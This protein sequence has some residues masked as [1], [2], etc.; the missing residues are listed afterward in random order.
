MLS[1]GDL[2]RADVVVRAE[3]APDLGPIVGDRVQLQQVILN[4]IRNA[5]DAMALVNDRPRQLTILTQPEDGDCVRVSVR[6][7][8]VGL[9]VHNAEHLF[10]A[11]YTTKHGGMGM[12]LSVSRSIVQNHRGCLWVTP[13]EGPGVTFSFS[14]PRR[15]P[16]TM[17]HRTGDAESPAL[18]AAAFAAGQP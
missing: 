8:G 3:L 12:G 18:A 2:Q 1:S 16:A 6:D 7:T 4:L 11:F 13:N 17:S 5:A 14:I 10:D 15:S 9:D